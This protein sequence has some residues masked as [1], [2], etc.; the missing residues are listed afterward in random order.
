ME[1]NRLLGLPMREQSD[2]EMWAAWEGW[3]A[4]HNARYYMAKKLGLNAE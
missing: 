2:E 3:A 1:L 4:G